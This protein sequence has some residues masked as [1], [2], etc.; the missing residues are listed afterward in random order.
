MT[1]EP[2]NSEICGKAFQIINTGLFSDISAAFLFFF[3]CRF[4]FFTTDNKDS[5]DS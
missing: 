5:M 2:I 3:H 1:Q 4:K